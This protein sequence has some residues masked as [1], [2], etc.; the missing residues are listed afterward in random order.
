[1]CKLQSP[2]QYFAVTF[3]AIHLQ[4]V[5]LCSEQV[6]NS[7]ILMPFSAP[8]VFLFPLFYISKMLAL[9]TFFNGGN[10]NKKLLVWVGRVGHLDLAVFWSKTVQHSAP[11]VGRCARKSPIME[12]AMRWKSLLKKFTEAKCSL[13]QK[14]QLVHW[15]RCAPR[16]LTEWGRPLLQGARPPEDNSI[17][18]WFPLIFSLVY[19][20]P[21]FKPYWFWLKVV[22][23]LLFPSYWQNKEFNKCSFLHQ[24]C[25]GSN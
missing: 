6:L 17:I 14:H 23:A 15:D 13:S 7:L 1:M 16:T 8:V 22:Y 3:H 4:S 9:R 18:P 25:E 10:N 19:S 20:K 21:V 5:F 2:S 24:L 11:D 12:W